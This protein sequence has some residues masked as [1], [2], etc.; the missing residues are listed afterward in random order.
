MLPCQKALPAGQAAVWRW[1]LLL[2]LQTLVLGW[3]IS[4]GLGWVSGSPS[5]CFVA[6]HCK[7]AAVTF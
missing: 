7:F 6:G 1:Q 2:V 3:I 5:S 4:A